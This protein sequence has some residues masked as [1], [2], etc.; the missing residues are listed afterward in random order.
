MK[1]LAEFIIQYDLVALQGVPDSNG[2]TLQT[3]KYEL[4]TLGIDY[5]SIGS[6]TSNEGQYAYLY[7]VDRISL[8]DYFTYDPQEMELI[9][10][11]PFIAEFIAI[12]GIFDF[13]LINVNT[14]SDNTDKVL[15]VIDNAV[16]TS[17]QY[18]SDEGDFI[19]IGSLKIGCNKIYNNFDYSFLIANDMV[20]KIPDYECPPD[21]I[22]LGL[23]TKEDY[24]NKTD[25]NNSNQIFGFTSTE[26][27]QINEFYT[28][29][30]AFFVNQDTDIELNN[31][32]EPYAAVNCQGCCS[33]HGGV[34]CANGVTKCQDGSSLSDTCRENGCNACSTTPISNQSSSSGGGGG[35]CFISTS[36]YGY[37]VT[38]DILTV[39][40]GS[41]FLV[42]IF[43]VYKKK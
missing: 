23:K 9:Q 21:F 11:K 24:A 26:S 33:S 22:R 17:Q 32:M 12:D 31:A 37:G 7:R 34:V 18:F 6:N 30:S 28:V 16:I 38:E 1:K 25:V 36:S 13:V 41:G 3:I 27:E 2:N 15:D 40:F 43:M 29:S 14:E 5:A 10:G 39:I 20:S 8:I 4:D 42:F 19:V 35:G